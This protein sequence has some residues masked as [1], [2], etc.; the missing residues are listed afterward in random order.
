MDNIKFNV[1]YSVSHV[2]LPL[3]A[4][5]DERLCNSTL[6]IVTFSPTLF[7]FITVQTPLCV[8]IHSIYQSAM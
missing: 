5:H 6:F 2:F 8:C 4:T 7:M 1:C 3:I